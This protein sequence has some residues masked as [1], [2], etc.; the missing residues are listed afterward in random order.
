VRGAVT[1]VGV[2][3]ALAGLAEL[4]G[5]IAS[6]TRRQADVPPGESPKTHAG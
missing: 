3:T 4:A 2:I 5:V 6:R 1:G